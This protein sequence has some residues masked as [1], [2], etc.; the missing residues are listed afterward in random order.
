M[1]FFLQPLPCVVATLASLL[2]TWMWLTWM[3]PRTT[4]PHLRLKLPPH[5]GEVEGTL[6]PAVITTQ[7]IT[8]RMVAV[9]NFRVVFPHLPAYRSD[10]A[11]KAIST[12]SFYQRHSHAPHFS[13][14]LPLRFRS[15]NS[16]CS[17]SDQCKMHQ[18]RSDNRSA[19]F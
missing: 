16:C 11:G 6:S 10:V 8:S 17:K 1:R 12:Q 5:M 4:C 13:A 3:S 7:R 2:S 19:L 14:S 15:H 18:K 9:M